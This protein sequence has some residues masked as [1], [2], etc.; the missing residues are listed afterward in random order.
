MSVEGHSRSNKES[1]RKLLYKLH[2]YFCNML[3]VQQCLLFD[4]RTTDL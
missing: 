1:R 3:K 4:R 2:S